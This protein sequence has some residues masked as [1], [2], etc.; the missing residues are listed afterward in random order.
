L[1]PSSGVAAPGS[2]CFP[3]ADPRPCPVRRCCALCAL[4][5]ANSLWLC[6]VGAPP[7]HAMAPLRCEMPLPLLQLLSHQ[8]KRTT[9]QPRGGDAA[10]CQFGALLGARGL[11]AWLPGGTWYLAVAPTPPPPFTP[12]S[13]RNEIQRQHIASGASH[14]A[15]ESGVGEARCTSPI[16]PESAVGY[17]FFGCPWGAWRVGAH[18]ALPVTRGQRGG[19]ELAAGRCAWVPSRCLSMGSRGAKSSAHEDDPLE[20]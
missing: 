9:S 5:P 11:G 19:E 3:A 13:A 14:L 17:V 1:G 2:P 6:L 12:G 7:V 8:G 4:L 16:A 10:G 20:A 15:P 18:L